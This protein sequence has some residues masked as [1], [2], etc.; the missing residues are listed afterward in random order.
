M[1]QVGSGGGSGR[2]YLVCS[3]TEGI[4][5]GGWFLLD[6]L[7]LWLWA[8]S[9]T[10][11]SCYIMKMNVQAYLVCQMPSFCTPGFLLGIFDQTS[12]FMLTCK[13]IYED[14]S[15]FYLII[16]VVCSKTIKKRGFISHYVVN[17]S[18]KLHFFVLKSYCL[19]SADYGIICTYSIYKLLSYSYWIPVI[20][21]SSTCC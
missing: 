19:E 3:Y 4:A 1:L 20:Y 13:C 7:P 6:C 14:V 9:A 8:V 21:L 15:A 2:G 16:F 12:F 18:L 5:F 11:L 10:P 17:I